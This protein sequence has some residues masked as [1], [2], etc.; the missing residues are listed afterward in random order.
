MYEISRNC[1]TFGVHCL[2]KISEMF[3]VSGAGFVGSVV[4]VHSCH[5]HVLF[6]SVQNH[7]YAN[8][9]HFFV[10]LNE[11]EFSKSRTFVVAQREYFMR[12]F[13]C[14]KRGKPDWLVRWNVTSFKPK[15][16]T[17]RIPRAVSTFSMPFLTSHHSLW[18]KP[19]GTF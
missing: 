6:D 19:L 3:W 4:C 18:E 10:V 13:F 2:W 16:K 17:L 8:F 1:S 15:P 11:Y 7:I 12:I 9:L 14:L 5:F